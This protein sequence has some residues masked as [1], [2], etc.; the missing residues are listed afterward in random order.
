MQKKIMAL[1]GAACVIG[2]VA[3]QSVGVP[4]SPSD[5][6]P[7]PVMG[8]V[9]AACN[10]QGYITNILKPGTVPFR[11]GTRVASFNLDPW[12]GGSSY[13][14]FWVD[15]P[16]RTAQT[17]FWDGI[18]VQATGATDLRN[19]DFVVTRGGKWAQVPTPLG[20]QWACNGGTHFV[21]SRPVSPVDGVTPV[22]IDCRPA[23]GSVAAAGTQNGRI[24]AW[25]QP[26]TFRLGNL[27]Q[28]TTFD[29]CTTVQQ[30]AKAASGYFGYYNFLTA[31]GLSPALTVSYDAVQGAIVRAANIVAP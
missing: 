16:A 28:A 5:P 12:V 24:S 18:Q 21:I 4:V 13:Q 14:R 7:T 10:V 8:P 2:P 29:R 15:F 31:T 3:A 23:A 20:A 25:L 6:S 17:I 22:Q 30:T 1:L 9:G 11:P 27:T 19:N 26:N